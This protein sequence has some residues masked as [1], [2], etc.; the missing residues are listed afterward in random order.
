MTKPATGLGVEPPRP[1]DERELDV[2]R[3]Y[4]DD[5]ARR[6]DAHRGGRVPGGY[7]DMVDALELGFLERYAAGRSVLE[8]GCG[9]GLLLERT[10]RFAKEARGVDLSAGMLERARARGLD[11]VQASATALPF[12]SASF[13]VACSFKTLPHVRDIR[14][15][16]GEMARVVRPGG[17]LVA[18]FYNPLSLRALAKRIA[19]PRAVS[20]ARTEADVYTRF[21]RPWR[22]ASLL[23]AGCR[24]VASRGVRIVT[25][26]AAALRLPLLGRLL[27]AAEQRLCDSPLAYLGGFWIVAARTPR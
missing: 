11:V 13:D 14:R 27:R 19:H 25:P 26:A 6:Y 3:A 17:V 7:H 2:T 12:E 1:P 4:Y 9:T 23:P 10:A 21:D 20:Q 22:V 16:L 24:I 8:V 18:E 15:A 5:F